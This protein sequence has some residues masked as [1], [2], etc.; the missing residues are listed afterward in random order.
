MKSKFRQ[1]RISS[2]PEVVYESLLQILQGNHIATSKRTKEISKAYYYYYAFRDS[3]S[4]RVIKNPVTG[5]V[6]M[7][8]MYEDLKTNQYVILL[9]SEEKGAC[10]EFFYKR[11]KGECAR[12]IKKRIDDVFAC[13]TEREIQVYTIQQQTKRSREGLKTNLH[14]NQLQ[15]RKCGRESK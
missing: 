2:I 6:E 7:R 10:I 11:A 12:K 5:V 14:S 8:I 15:Q 3:L 1:R 9:K 13:V 4:T